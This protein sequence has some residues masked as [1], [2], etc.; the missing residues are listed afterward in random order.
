MRLIIYIIDSVTAITTGPIKQ[1]G[2]MNGYSDM[3]VDAF[4]ITDIIHFMIGN[5]FASKSPTTTKALHKIRFPLGLSRGERSYSKIPFN[6]L[7]FLKTLYF[8]L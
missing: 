5:N 8:S 6:H 7:L 1:A 4:K 2:G 3:P